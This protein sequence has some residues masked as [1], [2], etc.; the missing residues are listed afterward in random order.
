ML[1]RRDRVEYDRAGIFTAD[2]V[3]FSEKYGLEKVLQSSTSI[4]G[5]LRPYLIYRFAHFVIYLPFL[6]TILE[7][8]PLHINSD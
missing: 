6:I 7:S 5:V 1:L 3:Y 2:H 8:L 4:A